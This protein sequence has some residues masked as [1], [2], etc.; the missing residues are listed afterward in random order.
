M[1]MVSVLVHLLNLDMSA[2]SNLYYAISGLGLSSRARL[3][4]HLP[5]FK[6]LVAGQRNQK[7]FPFCHD[8]QEPK[9]NKRLAQTGKDV[10]HVPTNIAQAAQNAC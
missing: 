8:M 5:T 6:I 9:K 1:I 4:L 2:F 10:H 7:R 3:H